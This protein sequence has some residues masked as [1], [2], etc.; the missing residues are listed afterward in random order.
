VQFT[1]TAPSGPNPGVPGVPGV[2]ES[3]GLPGLVMLESESLPRPGIA[4]SSVSP[5][6]GKPDTGL[7]DFDASVPHPA[8]MA[9]ATKTHAESCFIVCSSSF[10][11]IS[12]PPRGMW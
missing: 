8:T 10:Q 2:P 11:T 1:L 9:N 6:S 5:A 4:P 7:A 3:P 12:E